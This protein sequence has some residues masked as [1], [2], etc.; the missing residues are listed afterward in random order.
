MACYSFMYVELLPYCLIEKLQ[1]VII[2]NYLICDL[3]FESIDQIWM[4]SD[5]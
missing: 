1:L 3:S 5:I 2:L 4:S